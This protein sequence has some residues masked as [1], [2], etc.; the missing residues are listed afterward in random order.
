MKKKKKKEKKKKK[1]KKKKGKKRKK[2]MHAYTS[3]GSENIT[4]HLNFVMEFGVV[5]KLKAEFIASDQDV[6]PCFILFYFIF[7]LFYF[8]ALK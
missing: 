3:K 8:I 6:E 2:I 7:I 1:K 5:Y 4:S